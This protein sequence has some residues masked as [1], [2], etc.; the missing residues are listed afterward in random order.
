ME[1]FY[2]CCLTFLY[3]LVKNGESYQNTKVL[4]FTTGLDR[5]KMAMNECKNRT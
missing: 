2:S 5:S 4:V 1:G 3:C